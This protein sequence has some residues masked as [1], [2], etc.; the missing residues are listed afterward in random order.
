MHG[1]E[2][3]LGEIALDRRPALLGDAELPPE[4][5]LRSR[6][7]ETDEHARLDDRELGVEPRPARGELGGVRLVVDTTL[8]ARLPLE[9]LHRIRDVH[10]VAI[11]TGFVERSRSHWVLLPTHPTRVADFAYVILIGCVLAVT[12]LHGIRR[13]ALLIP[14]LYLAAFVW[15]NLLLENITGP[16][17]L[18]LLGA[19]LVVLMNARPQG[20]FGQPRVEIV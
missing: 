10:L 15:E 9:V 16:T 19:T 7:T 18:L 17:R 3:V 4:E 13:L 14:T 12:R 8:A 6:R 2:D 5:R 11:D 1:R 20:L